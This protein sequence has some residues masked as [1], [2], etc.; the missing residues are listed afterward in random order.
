MA[1]GQEAKDRVITALKEAF[2]TAFIGEIDKKIYVWS[3]EN[4]APQQVAITLTCPK[5]PVGDFEGGASSDIAMNNTAEITQ[6]EMDTI[7][8]LMLKLG[9]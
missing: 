5:T 3:V 2:G 7:A 9:L 1:K 6:E 8:E 4:G